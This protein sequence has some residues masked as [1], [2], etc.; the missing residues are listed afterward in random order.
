MAVVDP[1]ERTATAGIM[2]TARTIAS[3]FSPV[4]S[5]LAFGMAALGLPFFIAGGLK[6]VYDGLI[7]ATF[8]NIRPPEE[9]L[10]V[11]NRPAPH[12]DAA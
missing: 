5:G 3:A 7:Y 2:N 1:D 9:E 11:A 4:I 10:S 12:V 6:I 8:R